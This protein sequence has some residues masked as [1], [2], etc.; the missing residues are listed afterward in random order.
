VPNPKDC[1]DETEMGP[2]GHDN[3]RKNISAEV[4]I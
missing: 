2:A 1:S 4:K 3:R